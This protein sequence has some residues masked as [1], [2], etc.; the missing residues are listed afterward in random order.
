M[1][2]WTE[3]RSHAAVHEA[4]HT[5]ARFHYKVE[6]AC[7]GIDEMSGNEGPYFEGSSAGDFPGREKSP[8]RCTLGWTNAQQLVL[9][10]H[11]RTA[12]YA[13]FQRH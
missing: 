12:E 11:E 1:L 7:A 4:G 2:D 10:A 13:I 8:L 9:A 6:N 3:D 5:A